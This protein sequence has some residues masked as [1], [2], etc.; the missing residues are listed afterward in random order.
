MT[1]RTPDLAGL[2]DEA[3]RLAAKAAGKVL[4]DPRGQE[5]LARAAG[6]AQRGLAR[7]EALQS[8][9]MKAAGIPGRPEYQDLAR[10]LARVKRKAR[11]L[12]ERLERRTAGGRDAARGAAPGAS[13]DPAAGPGAGANEP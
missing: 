1:Q 12:N 6:L 7:L 9:A 10:R 13:T 8:Q 4:A 5:A 3:T 2:L 11:E